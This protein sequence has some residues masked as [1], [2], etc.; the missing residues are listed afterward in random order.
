MKNYTMKY[1][2]KRFYHATHPYVYNIGLQDKYFS[3]TNIRY[4]K[5]KTITIEV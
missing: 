5:K 2:F 4:T 1:K 3:S